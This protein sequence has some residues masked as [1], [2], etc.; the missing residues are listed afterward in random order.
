MKYPRSGPTY[1]HGDLP[2]KFQSFSM[3]ESSENDILKNMNVCFSD[4][5]EKNIIMKLK[6]MFNKIIDELNKK[7]P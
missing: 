1:V 2:K 7:N 3:V 5:S 6:K 4:A